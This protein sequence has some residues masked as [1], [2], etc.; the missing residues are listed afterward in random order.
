MPL[1]KSFLDHPFNTAWMKAECHLA[2]QILIVH[3]YA[4]DSYIAKESSMIQESW[5]L[6]MI[7]HLDFKFAI[8][9][10]PS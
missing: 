8:S 7:Q 2:N 1:E 5:V 10:F 3:G 9:Q 6:K 4:Y